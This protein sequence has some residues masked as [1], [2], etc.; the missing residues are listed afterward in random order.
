METYKDHITLSPDMN[1]ERLNTLRELFPDWFTQEG[2]LDV[3]E[4]KKAANPNSVDETERYEFRWFGKSAAKRNAFTPTRATLHYDAERSVNADTTENIIIEGENLEVLKILSSSYRGK[5]KCI[6]IDP[7]YNDE[8]DTIYNDNYAIDK[9]KYWEDIQLIQDGIVMDS[10]T[11]SSGRFHSDWMSNIYSRLLLARNLLTKDGV[12]FISINNRELHHL[13]IICD[14]LFGENNFIECITWNK[15]VPKNDK[16]IGNIHEY[17]LLYGKD[18]SIRKE[19]K[20]PKDGL[21]EIYDFVEKLKRAHIPLDEAEDRL[22][23]FYDRKGYDR[24]ITLY[25][26]LDQNYELW[27]KINMS[28]PNS[29]T[30]GEKYE[31]KH[32][33]SGKPVAIPDRGWRWAKNTFYEAAKI[34]EDGTYTSVEKRYDGSYVCGRISMETI[35]GQQGTLGREDYRFKVS[36]ANDSEGY[37]GRIIVRGYTPQSDS[38]VTEYEYELVERLAELPSEEEAA[39]YVDDKT[40]INFDGIPD[41]MI[42]IGR[43]CV[44]RV[45]EYYA[46][47]VWDDED[48][49]FAMVPGFDEISN[50]IVHAD[51]KT[52]TSTARTNAVEITTWTLAWEGGHLEIIDETTN[53]FGDIGDE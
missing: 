52:I 49:C 18:P 46:G 16:G 13:R 38:P 20:M 28:W 47:Y 17:I 40:D 5:I 1:E 36:F 25:C 35:H 37:I 2:N 29:N 21:D 12:I 14:E 30:F 42:F 3:N 48:K 51:T 8:A 27:G 50:P 9:N 4:V 22:K 26:N 32:P 19:F 33:V 53:T 43:N 31:V 39:N 41:L 7:P 11:E 34:D 44:G 15:R 10:C 45:S 24:G 6:Y 23:A